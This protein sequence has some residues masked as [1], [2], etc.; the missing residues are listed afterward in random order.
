[1]SAVVEHCERTFKTDLQNIDA[2]HMNTAKKTLPIALAAALLVQMGHEGVHALTTWLVGAQLVWFNL[3]A[4]NDVG[5]SPTGSLLISGSA[6]VVNILLSFACIALFSNASLKA[7]PSLRLF[8]FYFGAFNLFTGFGYLMTNGL[9]YS[10]GRLGDWN[11]VIAYFD[12][13]WAVRMPVILIGVAG[14]LYGFF[15]VP[16]SAQ[17]F[18]ANP[19][20]K[21]ERVTWG[22]G[23]LLIPYLVIN[24][25]MTILAIWHPL[26]TGNGVLLVGLHY[27]FGYFAVAW[28][29]PMCALW[30]TRNLPSKSDTT[31]LPNELNL[32]WLGVVAILFII[33]LF[34][35]FP[36][37]QI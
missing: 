7:R 9:F 22:L 4:V 37:P 10:S 6:A 18:V 11:S 13:S 16:Q 21:A 3:F 12:G 29:F 17:H 5:A 14:T 27:W 30:L 15:W 35:L 25:L 2:I 20:D 8:V 19:A 31:P 23:A 26:G 32:I 1:M 24:T 36:V 34:V 28:G 33:S